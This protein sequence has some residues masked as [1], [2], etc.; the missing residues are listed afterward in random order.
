L[1]GS[2]SAGVRAERCLKNSS[3]FARRVS[4]TNKPAEV[5]KS[6]LKLAIYHDS[7]IKHSHRAC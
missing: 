6:E 2:S 5:K 7:S 4:T 1:S 3:S